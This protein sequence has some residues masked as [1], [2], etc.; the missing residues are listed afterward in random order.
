M[1]FCWWY[2]EPQD[3]SP[4]WGSPSGVEMLHPET[5]DFQA[6]WTRMAHVY[7]FVKK[8][9]GSCF[10]SR[11]FQICYMFWKNICLLACCSRNVGNI[12]CPPVLA[13]KID[14]NSSYI[15]TVTNPCE[16]NDTWSSKRSPSQWNMYFLKMS[17]FQL[18]LLNFDRWLFSW[19]SK[20]IPPIPNPLK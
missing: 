14:S 4:I 9:A 3:Y 15:L 20:G 17:F 1:C 6:G 5:D 18:W 7:I 2:L 11:W 8:R 19:G 13:L 10:C 16:M 12:W